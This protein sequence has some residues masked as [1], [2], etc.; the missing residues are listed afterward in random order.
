[1][2]ASKTK[3]AGKVLPKKLHQAARSGK[4]DDVRNSVALASMAAGVASGVNWSKKLK[5]DSDPEKAKMTAKSKAENLA[6]AMRGDFDKGMVSSSVVRTPSGAKTLRR[7]THAT[8]RA[9]MIR[10]KVKS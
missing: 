10:P 6:K 5:R 4:A 1:M 2:L 7:A 3:I 9:K 8:R